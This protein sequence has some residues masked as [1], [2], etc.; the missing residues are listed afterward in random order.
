M[1]HEDLQ[2]AVHKQ[3]FVPFRLLVSTGISFDIH[4]PDLI[5]VGR[6]AVVVGIMTDNQVIAHGR[7]IK[8]DL[9]HVVAIEELPRLGSTSN[10][11]ASA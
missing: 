6:R 7:D 4:H 9:L 1:T 11:S 8:I 5:V 10:G 2:E 3:L